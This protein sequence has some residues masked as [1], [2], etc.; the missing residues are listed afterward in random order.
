MKSTTTTKNFKK[1]C[2]KKKT[3]KSTVV[4]YHNK[5]RIWRKKETHQDTK[6]CRSK[7]PDDR[8]VPLVVWFYTSPTFNHISKVAVQEQQRQQKKQTLGVDSRKKDRCWGEAEEQSAG[9][10]L[11]LGG[12]GG[13][14][15]GGGGGS[16][17]GSGS[18]GGGSLVQEERQAVETERRENEGNVGNEDT[19]KNKMMTSEWCLV[20]QECSCGCGHERGKEREEGMELL[21]LVGQWGLCETDKVNAVPSCERIQNRVGGGGGVGGLSRTDVEGEIVGWY[22]RGGEDGESYHG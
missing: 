1:K 16:G 5:L 9:V 18:G 13:G 2:Q 14:G 19:R 11:A 4:C 22:N 15:G 17:S 8:V 10:R 20:W 6:D 21:E 7:P 12:S 3:K